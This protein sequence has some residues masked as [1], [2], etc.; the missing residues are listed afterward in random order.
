MN[1]SEAYINSFETFLAATNEKEV[2]LEKIQGHFMHLQPQNVLEIGPGNGDISIP[3]SKQS[4]NYLAVEKNPKYVE[5][6]KKEGLNVIEGVFPVALA[7]E[8]DLILASHAV[9]YE[10]KGVTEFIDAAW[11]LLKPKG[12]LVVITYRDTEDDWSK[13]MRFLGYDLGEVDSENFDTITRKLTSLG[14]LETEVVETHVETKTIKDMINALSFVASDGRPK[15]AQEFISKAGKIEAFLDSPQYKT[16]TG[17][18]FPFQHF[19]LLT[20]KI[21]SSTH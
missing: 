11:L 7:D 9:S 6:L 10:N 5:R 18:Q 21:D 15:K 13:L 8:F 20:R 14:E 4:P 17:H 3:I 19:F 12:S 16:N 2:L 1:R